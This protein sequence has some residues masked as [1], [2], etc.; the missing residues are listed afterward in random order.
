M[1]EYLESPL[2]FVIVNALVAIIVPLITIVVP[3]CFHLRREREQWTKQQ[4][5]MQIERLDNTTETL[6]ATIAD[7]GDVEW[8]SPVGMM[9]YEA[10]FRKDLFA[11]ERSAWRLAGPS[12]RDELLQTRGRLMRYSRKKVQIKES[13]LSSSLLSL[14]YLIVMKLNE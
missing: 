9:Q 10:K 1:G 11:W 2:I 7:V 4:H 8:N 13:E 14:T 12:E 5:A 3:Q 6:L